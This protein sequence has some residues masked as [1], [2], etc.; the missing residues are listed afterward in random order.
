MHISAAPNLSS[1]ANPRACFYPVFVTRPE[2]LTE[3]PCFASARSDVPGRKSNTFP[4]MFVSAAQ[5][6]RAT[7]TLCTPPSNGLSDVQIRIRVTG[8]NAKKK[9][10]PL[11]EVRVFFQS[12]HIFYGVHMLV[13][14]M[15]AI[16]YK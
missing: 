6:T 13:M 14:L 9:Q 5:V 12:Y 15:C 7:L 4:V 8:Q 16:T 10:L 1:L 3:V 11:T 2:I